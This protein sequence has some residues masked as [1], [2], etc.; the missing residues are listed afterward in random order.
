MTSEYA[1]YVI[2]LSRLTRI[3]E[4]KDVEATVRAVDLKE[5]KKQ[6]MRRGRGEKRKTDAKPKQEIID[7]PDET[8][9]TTIEEES[10]NNASSVSVIENLKRPVVVKP[11]G[12]I[13]LL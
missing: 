11:I 13:Q 3:Y 12:V 8:P 1:T 2:I 6:I 9:A 10:K 7:L 4:R 5:A